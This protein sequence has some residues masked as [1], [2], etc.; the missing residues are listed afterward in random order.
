MVKVVVLSK[1]SIIFCVYS[2]IFLYW[3]GWTPYVRT[4]W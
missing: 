2:V 4:N 3:N 1:F